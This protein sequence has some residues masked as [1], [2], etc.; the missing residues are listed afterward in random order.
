MSKVITTEIFCDGCSNWVE[1][2]ITS[3]AAIQQSRALA[4]REGWK[5]RWNNSRQQYEDVCP[6][7]LEAEKTNVY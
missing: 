1:G 7:C 6:E 4:R 5:F 3:R 2:T